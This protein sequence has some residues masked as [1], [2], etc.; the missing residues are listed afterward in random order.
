MFYPIYDDDVNDDEEKSNHCYCSCVDRKYNDYDDFKE[1]CKE[2]INFITR[3]CL[4]FFILSH[5]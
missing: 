1:I 3:G 4:S 2:I 5:F